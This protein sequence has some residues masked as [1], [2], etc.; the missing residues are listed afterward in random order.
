[1]TGEL[2]SAAVKLRDSLL[3][4]IPLARTREEHV[5]VTARATSATELVHML[6]IGLSHPPM[7]LEDLRS[8]VEASHLPDAVN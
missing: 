5:R 7:P 1:M 6:S 8:G 2:M 4:D 3:S